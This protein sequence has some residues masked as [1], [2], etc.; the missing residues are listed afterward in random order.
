MDNISLV[1]YLDMISE[2]LSSLVSNKDH[3]LSYKVYNI[4][5]DVDRVVNKK[6]KSNTPI[7]YDTTYRIE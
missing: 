7:D 2:K 5:L 3:G 6:E 4:A 1:G